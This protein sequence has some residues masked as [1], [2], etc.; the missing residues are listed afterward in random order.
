MTEPRE[1]I[2]RME[3]EPKLPGGSDV[4]FAGYAVLGLPFRSGHLLALR[5]FPA[6]SVGPAYTSVWH[7]DP[8]GNLLDPGVAAVELIN[9]L[10]PT[11]AVARYVAFAAV[12]LH[13][14]PS[15]G[16]RSGTAATRRSSCSCRRCAGSTRSSRSSAAGSF[17]RSTGEGITSAG[18]PRSCSTCTAPTTI[19]GSGRSRTR[20]GRNGSAAGRA[21]PSRL[22]HKGAASMPRII[23]A[24]GK[25][26]QSR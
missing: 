12:A 25:G 24:R 26:S 13:E 20:F 8:Y 16:R 5:R 18:G 3:A 7:R 14:F 1:A 19:P 11:V 22:F 10:R 4:R 15:G 23:A 9:I 6:S 2:Q 21:T 17:S